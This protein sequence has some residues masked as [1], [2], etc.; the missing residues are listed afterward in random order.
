MDGFRAAIKDAIGGSVAPTPAPAPT[1]EVYYRVRKT[2]AD[3]GS[4]IGAYKKPVNAYKC[5]DK[6]P[7]YYVFDETGKAIYPT[8]NVPAPGDTFSPYLV[9]I[10]A[11]NLNIRTGPGTNYGLN[12]GIKDR[13][14]YTIVEVRDGVGSLKGWGKLKSGAGWVSLDY[15][16]KV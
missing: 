8:K 15:A 9:R 14:I 10:K 16:E 12:G 3:A 1:A 13:G 2:W 7:G 11:T 6:N 4:Q 5:A